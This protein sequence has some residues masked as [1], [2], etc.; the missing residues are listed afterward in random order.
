MVTSANLSKQA[1][2]ELENKKGEVWI[3]SWETGV[4]V[5]P[6]LYDDPNKTTMVPV[7]GKD[8]PGPDDESKVVGEVGGKEN[9]KTVI[10]FRMPYDL[11]LTPYLMDEVPW[12]A[13]LPHT[14]PD[15]MG[16]TWTGY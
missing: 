5:W 4:V 11:P 14:E 3:Q 15:W 8:M 10:G 9:G 13:T 12:C 7:F 6:A 2:G 1:W 16:R